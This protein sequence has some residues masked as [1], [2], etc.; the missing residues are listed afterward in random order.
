VDQIGVP[1][2]SNS[3]RQLE[4]IVRSPV[5]GDSEIAI[6]GEIGWFPESKSIIFRR[7]APIEKKD[8]IEKRLVGP[9]PLESAFAVPGYPLRRRAPVF[10]CE[11]CDSA[12]FRNLSLV[13]EQNSN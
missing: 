3:A 13:A 2:F 8:S 1:V 6:L 10:S 4:V 11:S 9:A 7:A 5:E 12:Q